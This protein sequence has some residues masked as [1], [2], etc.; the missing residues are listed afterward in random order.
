MTARGCS[1]APQKMA[2]RPDDR[3]RS[4]RS[5]SARKPG[6]VDRRHVAQAEDHDRRQ[7]IDPVDHALKFVGRAEEKRAVDAKNRHVV[8]NV[9]VLE[10]VHA[11]FFQVFGRHLIDGRRARH[12]PDVEQRGENH[13]DFD[14]DREV[15]EDG[16]RKRRHPDGDVGLGLTQQHRNLVPLTHVR[17]DDEQ[18]GGQYGHRHVPGQARAEEQQAEQRQRVD[19]PGHGCAGARSNVGRRAG[20]GA[21]RR[22]AAEHRRD[23]VGDALGDELDV[24]IVPIA[25]HA[26]GDDRRHQRLDRAEHRDG[27]GRREQREDER[28]PKRRDVKCRQARGHGAKSRRHGLDRQLGRPRR[29]RCPQPGRP[30]CRESPSRNGSCRARATASSPTDPRR[31]E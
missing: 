9:L 1:R 5:S 21:R 17:R 26:I 4:V 19:H 3:S 23:D 2:V 22:Q 27:E 13:P 20:D 18:D 10:D 11:A 28:R 15:G 30:R 14:G 31:R 6:G 7:F 24:R 12:A 29:R 8:G 16:Q 25:A